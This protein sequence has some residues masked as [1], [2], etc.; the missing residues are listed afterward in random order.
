MFILSM[1]SILELPNSSVTVI[2]ITQDARREET[3][4]VYDKFSTGS[5]S[6]W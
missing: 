4:I 3:T 1:L 2:I 5:G 6:N